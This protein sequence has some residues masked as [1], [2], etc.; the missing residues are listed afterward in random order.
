MR[1]P[2]ERVGPA[3]VASSG[4]PRR[5]FAVS[6]RPHSILENYRLRYLRS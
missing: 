3:D 5:D 4:D 2:A 1:V 6:A